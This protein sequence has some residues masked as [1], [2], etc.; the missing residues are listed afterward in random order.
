MVNKL[1]LLSVINKYYLGENESVKWDI[2]NECLTINFMSSNKE[3]MGKIE[4]SKFKLEDCELAIF[5]TKKLLNLVNISA[6]DLLIELEK[7]NNINTKLKISDTNFNLIYA[8]ADPILI[9]KPAN[10][11][12]I[13]WEVELKLEYKD[14][15]NMVKAKNALTDTPTVYV[16]TSKNLDGD[17]VCEFVFGDIQG[18]SNKVI[19]QMKGN[20]KIDNLN[21]PFNAEIFKNILHY[22]K[23]MENGVIRFNSKG[24]MGLEFNNDTTKST[25]YMVRK[26]ENNF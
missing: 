25:Y 22:N 23:D 21:L 16:I 26:T 3:V 11:K 20:I 2:K 8:L 4:H 7:N 14:L 17:T 24:L 10:V 15:E 1:K 19:Y 9:P 6:G 12:D 18:H 5:D 13:E